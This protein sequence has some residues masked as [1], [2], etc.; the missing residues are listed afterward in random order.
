MMQQNEG[1]VNLTDAM[2]YKI[3]LYLFYDLVYNK[4]IAASV[5]ILYYCLEHDFIVLKSS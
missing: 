4:S 1:M 2:N 5:I 3:K